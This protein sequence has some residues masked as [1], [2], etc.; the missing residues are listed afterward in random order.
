MCVVLAYLKNKQTKKQL[1][2]NLKKREK[3]AKVNS[4]H[5]STEMERGVGEN[6]LEGG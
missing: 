6:V 3:N 4:K 1:V 5:D 2:K